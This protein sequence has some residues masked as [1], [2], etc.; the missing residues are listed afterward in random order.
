[1]KCLITTV[2]MKKMPEWLALVSNFVLNHHCPKIHTTLVHNTYLTNTCLHRQQLV[3][4]VLSLAKNHKVEI[5]DTVV[6]FIQ[7]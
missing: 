4:N 3:V 6:K 2:A 1:M 5:I 7:L